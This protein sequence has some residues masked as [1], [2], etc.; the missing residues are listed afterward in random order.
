MIGFFRKIRKQLADDNRFFK[1][2]RYAIGEIVLVVIGILIALQINNWNIYSKLK[3]QEETIIQEVERNIE[4]NIVEMKLDLEEIS[5]RINSIEIIV[6]HL[7]SELVYH[8]SLAT[9]FGR[10]NSYR[11]FNG[12]E[13]G[14]QL[15]LSSGAENIMN[16]NLRISLTTYF[17]EG[18][19][20]INHSMIL[21]Q[22]HYNQYILDIF[23]LQFEVDGTKPFFST[24]A[25]TIPID[26]NNLKNDKTITNSLNLFKSVH[27]WTQLML[28]S[29]IDNSEKTLM[30][31][32]EYMRAD[33]N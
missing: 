8:D 26:Y 22:D 4:S 7:N 17:G 27:I 15:M 20:D 12:V 14:Y 2:S 10:I 24:T 1:Y 18:L 6:A 13:T 11:Y 3:V 29:S 25:K 16:D 23:R 5:N 32:K 30:E 31:I 21:L 33:F 28:K 19:E 9:H